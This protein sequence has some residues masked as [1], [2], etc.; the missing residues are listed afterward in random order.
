MYLT[1]NKL[2]LAV[3]LVCGL[4]IFFF[5]YDQG[6]MSSVNNTPDCVITMKFGEAVP[7]NESKDRW[8]TNVTNSSKLGG[9]V[10]IYYPGTL[11]GAV[12]GGWLGGQV[13]QNKLYPNCPCMGYRRSSDPSSGSKFQLDAVLAA[14]QWH[15]YWPSERNC[16][17]VVR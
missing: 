6:M 7:P 17:S 14:D 5:G 16:S 11:A 12:L 1:G 13:W 10:S 2:V 15:W 3:N 9:I 4:S 8:S